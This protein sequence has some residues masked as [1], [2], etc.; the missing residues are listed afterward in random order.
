MLALTACTAA[1]GD[2]VT[3]A[4]ADFAGVEAAGVPAAAAAA[5]LMALGD[6]LYVHWFGCL[7]RCGGVSMAAAPA[8]AARTGLTSASSCSCS[9]SSSSRLR[10]RPLMDA[11]A[12]VKLGVEARGV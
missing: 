2:L 9:S 12:P 5:A 6:C 8:A 7:G 3:A 10:F 1:A 11:I 4:G